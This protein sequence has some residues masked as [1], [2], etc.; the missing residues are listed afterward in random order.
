MMRKG[1]IILLLLG[2]FTAR[3]QSPSQIRK[4]ASL[5]QAEGQAATLYAADSTALMRLSAKIAAR[6]GISPEL[7]ATYL[8]DLRR[9]SSRIVEGRYTVLR[10]L[11]GDA[12]EEVFAPR[13]E[14]VRQLEERGASTGDPQFYTLAYTLARS[15][16]AYP[17]D[18]LEI[19][20]Q[21]ASGSWT[22]EDFVSREAEAVLA[23]LEPRPA[24][25]VQPAAK[26][27][28]PPV[29]LPVTEHVTVT[30]TVIVQRDLGRIEVEHVFGRRDTVVIIPGVRESGT[31]AVPLTRNARR[32]RQPKPV[33]GFVLAQAGVLPDLSVGLM[34]GLDGAKYGGYLSARSNFRSPDSAYDCRSDGTTDYGQIWTNGRRSVGRF[35]LTGGAWC[36]LSGWMKLYAGAGYGSRLVCW[37]DTRSTWARVTDYSATGLTTEL[38]VIF[39][40][41]RLALSLGGEAI[42]FRQFALTL[43]AG[44]CF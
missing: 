35:A 16:P 20:R 39:Q 25:S 44:F 24:P 32:P 36:Q 14:R 15:L 19:L 34:A 12:L 33:Q 21:K 22:L 37:Q 41:G 17:A 4:D 23:A 18:S 7:G 27:Q 13:R 5:L 43:G 28:N 2:A 29:A 11:A 8:E 40:P 6:C 42:A 10:Y 1:F 9:T 3:A 30:D 38:G 26:P 31:T